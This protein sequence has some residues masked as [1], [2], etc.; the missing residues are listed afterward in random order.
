[1]H[2]PTGNEPPQT[3]PFNLLD[4]GKDEILAGGDTWN[5][6]IILPGTPQKAF[7]LLRGSDSVWTLEQLDG[8][9]VL[10]NKGKVPKGS[11]PIAN[12]DC[13]RVGEWTLQYWDGV[14]E[15]IAEGIQD[16][17]PVRIEDLSVVCDGLVILENICFSVNSGEFVGIL[18]PSGCGKSSLIERIANLADWTQGRIDLGLDEKGGPIL[19]KEHSFEIAYVPQD[20]HKGLH[21]NLTVWQE[22]DCHMR[23]RTSASPTDANRKSGALA[24]LGLSS[25]RDKRVGDLSGGQKRRLAFALALLQRPKLV[26][27]DEPTS[28]LDP[29]AEASLMKHLEKLSRQG[30]TVICSTHMLAN[31][32]KF[33]HVLILDAKGTQREYLT[34]KQLAARN[35]EGLVAFYERL[36]AEKRHTLEGTKDSAKRVNVLQHLKA[37]ACDLI[38]RLESTCE[39]SRP[40][41]IRGY[42]VRQWHELTSPIVKS[43]TTNDR[44]SSVGKINTIG[45]M[46]SAIKEGRS[47]AWQFFILPLA[48][49]FFIRFGLRDKFTDSIHDYTVATFCACLA[50]FWLGMSNAVRLLVSE[51]IPGRC[52][53][54]LDG[55][56]VFR[57]IFAKFSWCF[58]CALVQSA[59][60]LALYYFWKTFKPCSGGDVVRI[61]PVGIS[62]H[63]FVLA[64]VHWMGGGVGLAVS[65]VTAK[66]TTALTWVPLIGL[67][68][69]LFGAPVLEPGE[70]ASNEWEGK[71]KKQPV[72]SLICKNV[73]PCNPA[74]VVLDAKYEEFEINDGRF[75]P[76]PKE[77][78]VRKDD[79]DDEDKNRHANPIVI[80]LIRALAYLLSCFIISVVAQPINES[81]WKGR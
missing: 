80:L 9:E 6:D 25:E 42:I 11:C 77:K 28:G 70:A 71:E 50:S 44:K 68:V 55:V 52:L 16:G 81:G 43:F 24:V 59:V 26:L 63:F 14:L 69:L 47:V 41:T 21:E 36:S 35:D 62:A 33:S 10:L 8:T 17:F 12:G 66:E 72:A 39:A 18:G 4:S 40:R 30:C 32:D 5:S 60:F 2:K 20:A 61:E 79:K 54:G 53:E 56:G 78:Q 67:V 49:A 45:R 48:M 3:L 46:W 19:A 37:L 23:L 57:Y 27:L 51:R 73:M 29:A 75:I 1:M 7:R 15:S 34:P 13:I 76:V 38:A 31:L 58:L 74:E 22:L 64:L 65:A